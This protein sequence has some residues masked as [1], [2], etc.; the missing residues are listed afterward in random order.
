M[1]RFVREFVAGFLISLVFGGS[2][3]ALLWRL[4]RP[5][6]PIECGGEDPEEPDPGNPAPPP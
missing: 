2:L 6:P 1:K 5:D 4:D 3:V